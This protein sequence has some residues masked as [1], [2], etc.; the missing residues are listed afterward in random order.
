[1]LFTIYQKAFFIFFHAG[2]PQMTKVAHDGRAP[3]A[4]PRLFWS[5][6]RDVGAPA[7]GETATSDIARSVGGLSHM[8]SYVTSKPHPVHFFVHVS[9]AASYTSSASAQKLCVCETACCC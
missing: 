2:A 3:V 1:M 5:K 6:Q 8:R 9:S 7:P 4:T